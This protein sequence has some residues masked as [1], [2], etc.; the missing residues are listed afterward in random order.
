[1]FRFSLAAT[2]FLALF[3]LGANAEVFR[4]QKDGTTV[5]SDKPCADDAQAYNPKPIQIVPSVKAPDLAKQY[6]QRVTKE[7]KVRDQANESWNKEYQEQKKQDETIRDA[8]IDGK[9]VSGM[10]QEQVRSMLG[11]PQVT[12]H[13]E[14]LGVV[15]EG[16]TYKN[17]DGSRTLVYFKDGLVTGTS[18]KKGK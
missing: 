15:R 12:S 1:M 13:N 3:P 16:W 4:C 11:K 14:N 7:I 9:V 17:P 10:S 18:S 2:L 6:D 8:R 5:F